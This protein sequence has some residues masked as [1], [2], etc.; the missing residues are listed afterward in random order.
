MREG[1]VKDKEGGELRALQIDPKLGAMALVLVSYWLVC[2]I[3]TFECSSA[4]LV[5]L[6]N[7]SGWPRL[8][9]I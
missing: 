7:H 3:V 2:R 5:V 4:V 6:V 8:L 1:Q 9:V